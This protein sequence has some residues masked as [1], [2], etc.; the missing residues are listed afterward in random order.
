M[1]QWAG[2]AD[3]VKLNEEELALLQGREGDL[4][5]RDEAFL[6]QH[7]LEGLVVTRG[8]E[9][10]T[11]LTQQAPAFHVAPV[12]ALRVVDTVGAGDALASVLLVG[13]NR[14]WPMRLTLERAQQ[15]ASAMVGQRGATVDDPEFYRPFVEAWG[16]A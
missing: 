8:S 9:G 15:F 16:M 6:R 2:Q 14:G 3:W 11:L 1:L 4:T 12:E 13:L 5:Q 7:R 10:A